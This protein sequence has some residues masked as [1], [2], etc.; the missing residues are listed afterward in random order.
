MKETAIA[1]ELKK[2]FSDDD[3]LEWYLNQVYY[4][5]SSYGAEAASQ[6]YFGKSAR[7]LTLAEACPPRRAPAGAVRVQP[8]PSRRTR[9]GQRPGSCRCLT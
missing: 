1:L 8:E 4:G 6:R 3:I 2:R 9:N 5:H 7:D